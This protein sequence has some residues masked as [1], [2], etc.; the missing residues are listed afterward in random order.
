MKRI[1]IIIGSTREGRIGRSIAEHV[2]KQAKNSDKGEYE[3]IDLREVNLP[4]M[5]EPLPPAMGQYKHEHT[6]AWSKKISSYDAFIIVTSEYNHGYPAPLKN[7][8]D[9]VYVE[10]NHKPVAFVG[11]G[12]T[13]NGARSVGALRS[14]TAYLQMKPVWKD[15]LINLAM[16]SKDGVFQSD[17]RIDGAIQAAL[18]DLEKELA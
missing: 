16:N 10:W 18:S 6:K 9:T 2:L 1:G 15:V 7:A 11:Y 17:D 3:L 14:I 4:F 12:Y 5:N 8:L 13:A